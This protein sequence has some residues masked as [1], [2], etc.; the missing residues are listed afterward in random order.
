MPGRQAAEGLGV[1]HRKEVGDAVRRARGVGTNALSNRRIDMRHLLFP[2][3]WSP[4][5][6]VEVVVDHRA[7]GG[8][9]QSAHQAGLH[10]GAVAAAALDDAG[11]E[12]AEYV[13]KREDLLL[14]GP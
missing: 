1:F 6:L 8:L 12:F 13:A 10:L 14:L 9:G 7:A 5:R 2:L 4:H 11:A 3:V